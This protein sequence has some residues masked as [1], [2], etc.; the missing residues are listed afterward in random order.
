MDDFRN[1]GRGAELFVGLFTLA[2]SA[3][4]LFF[5]VDGLIAFSHGSHAASADP[6]WCSVGIASGLLLG[7][8]GTRLVRGSSSGAVLLSN[9]I[10]FC[11]ALALIG[12]AGLLAWDGLGSHKSVPVRDVVGALALGVSALGL[13]RRRVRGD[14]A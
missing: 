13:W 7:F 6:L 5:G 9:P 3:I 4:G 12:S 14:A 2:A 11:C 10:L 1:A 8:Y